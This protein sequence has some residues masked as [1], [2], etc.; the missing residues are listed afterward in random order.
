MITSPIVVLI[1]V[2]VILLVVASFVP[3]PGNR[4]ATICGA[5]ALAFGLILLLLGLLGYPVAA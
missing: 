2:G 3:A 1:V 4:I 5:L